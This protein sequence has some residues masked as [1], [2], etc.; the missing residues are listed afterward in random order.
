MCNCVGTVG[1]RPICSW[2]ILTIGP[3]CSWERFG[4]L[5][6]YTPF[7]TLNPCMCVGV[8]GGGIHI[9]ICPLCVHVRERR[10]LQL[11]SSQNVWCVVSLVGSAGFPHSNVMCQFSTAGDYLCTVR[12]TKPYILHM[13]RVY[14]T[15]HVPQWVQRCPL[16]CLGV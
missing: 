12:V 4:S 6:L 10:D 16:T 7:G 5:G 13:Y 14:Y 15:T 8:W 9:V 11:L 2:G 3:K 1:C